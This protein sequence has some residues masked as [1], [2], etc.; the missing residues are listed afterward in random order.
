MEEQFKKQDQILKKLIVEA[1]DEAPSPEFKAKLMD[2][3]REKA[4]HKIVY[5]PLIPAKA[6]AG[7]AVL[8]IA[9]AVI[10]VLFP[11]TG[12]LSKLGIDTLSFESG[13][14]LP[15]PEFSKT[16]VYGVIFLSLFLLQVPFLKKLVEARYTGN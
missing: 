8:F 1:G 4:E 15:K 16:F 10:A 7:V 11:S 5:K 9:V 3:I 13:I 2:A 12:L 14:N 6:W